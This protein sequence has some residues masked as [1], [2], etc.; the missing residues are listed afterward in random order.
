MTLSFI[1]DLRLLELKE[2]YVDVILATNIKSKCANKYIITQSYSTNY[3]DKLSVSI[4]F[5]WFLLYDNYQK[6][7]LVINIRINILQL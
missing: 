3:I 2:L 4:W 1:I 7:F 6:I 5:V